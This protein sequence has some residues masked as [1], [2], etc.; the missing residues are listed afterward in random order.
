MNDVRNEERTE[1]RTEENGSY[2]FYSCSR[3]LC[4]YK[5]RILWNRHRYY[6]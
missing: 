3:R 2:A 4:A 6:G 1:E 5:Q